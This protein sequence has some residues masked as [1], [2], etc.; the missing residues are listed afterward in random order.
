MV[1]TLVR[2]LLLALLWVF[3]RGTL[4]VGNVLLGFVFGAG[5]LQ[6]SA[7]L[8]DADDPAESRRL[9]EGGRLLV[10]LWRVLVLFLAFLR[11]LVISALQTARYTLQ[12][13][14]QIN[15]AVIEYPLDVK[16]GREITVLANLIS[17]TPGTLSMDVSPDNE[18]LY[19]HAI[20]VETSDGAE[21]VAD[22]KESLEKNVSRALG[23]ITGFHGN[24]V[25]V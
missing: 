13:T 21:V 25:H 10:R 22:I 12:P 5:I 17:L 20:S 8:F 16:T 9:R 3:L 7:P 4:S 18:Y 19:V 2:L 11:E 14:L 1:A 6:L 24:S 15:P 23:P